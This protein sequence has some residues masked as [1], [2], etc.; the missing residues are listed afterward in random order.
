MTGLIILTGNFFIH[1]VESDSE[2][3]FAL[4]NWVHEL[5]RREISPFKKVNVI[6]FT[7]E[8]PQR[9][10]NYWSH[11]PTQPQ[12]TGEEEPTEF[13]TE[14]VT[15][16]LYED[17]LQVGT[18]LSKFFTDQKPTPSGLAAA[19]KSTSKE[20]IPTQERLNLMLSCEFPSIED[21]EEIY[22]SGIDIVFEDELVWPPP[23]ERTF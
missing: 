21:F 17:M 6:S 5:L 14:E 1:F 22:M 8:N 10:F 18:R 4:V 13:V 20:L 19:L 2:T 9:L 23:P 16:K 7:E 3:L 11:I 15:W 12:S